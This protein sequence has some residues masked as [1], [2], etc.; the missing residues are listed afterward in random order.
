MSVVAFRA[1]QNFPFYFVRSAFASLLACARIEGGEG[2][3]C[4]AV[5]AFGGGEGKA[6]VAALAFGGGEKCVAALAFLE[7]C[8]SLALGWVMLV[9]G[10][11]V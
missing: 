1:P 3:A 4:I 2:K 11:F 6:C 9:I 10:R 5:L 8:A 7:C